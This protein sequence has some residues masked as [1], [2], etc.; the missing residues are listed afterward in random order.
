MIDSSSAGGL[1]IRNTT[2][3]GNDAQV[4][5][6][7][8]ATRVGRNITVTASTFSN[9]NAVVP[10]PVGPPGRWSGGDGGGLAVD[11]GDRAPS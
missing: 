3:D 10:T 11:T 8:F 6:G 7:V 1:T 4:G 5:G 9:N 2:I